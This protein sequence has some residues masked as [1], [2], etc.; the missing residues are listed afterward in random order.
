VSFGV[1]IIELDES[2]SQAFNAVNVFK[3][4]TGSTS[5]TSPLSLASYLNKNDPVT[6]LAFDNFARILDVV[7]GLVNKGKGKTLTDTKVTTISGQTAAINVSQDINIT[8]TTP[9][10]SNGI[11]SNSTQI[12]TIQAGTVV[13]ITPTVQADGNVFTDIKIE[14]SVPGKQ[15]SASVA[16]NVSR[17]QVTN[18]LILRDG[19]TVEIGGLIQHNVQDNQVRI[20]ILGY[21]PIIGDLLSTTSRSDETSELLVFVTAYVNR[22]SPKPEVIQA[23]PNPIRIDVPDVLKVFPDLKP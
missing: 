7:D 10:T 22:R 23:D 3:T 19:E 6:V 18:K 20:P 2:G 16:P 14:S 9:T 11:T 5:G 17:R 15:A 4:G 12:Q 21:L 13:Q 8:T 1:K